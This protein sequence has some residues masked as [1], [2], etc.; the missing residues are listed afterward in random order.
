MLVALAVG[1]AIGFGMTSAAA[2]ASG[3]VPLAGSTS[4]NAD[5][6]ARTLSKLQMRFP[7]VMVGDNGQV[8][9]ANPL[10][11]IRHTH[12]FGVPMVSAPSAALAAEQFI[13]EYRAV[14]GAGQVTL[15]LESVDDVEFGKFTLF[16]YTQSIDGMPV[17]LSL[18]RVLVLNPNGHVHQPTVVLASAKLAEVSQQGFPA[19]AISSERALK[20]VQDTREFGHLPE[21]STPEL[22]VYFAEGD[23]QSFGGKWI[24]PVRVWRFTGSNPV[25][26]WAQKRTFFVDAASGKL[27]FARNEILH[28]PGDISGV[29]RANITPGVLPDSTTNPPQPVLFPDVRVSGVFNGGPAVNL[30]SDASG[31]FNFPSVPAGSAVLTANVAVGRWFTLTETGGAAIT[32]SASFTAPDATPGVADILLNAVP[33]EISTAQA[34]AFYHAHR[35]REFLRSR[36]PTF[37]AL[38]TTSGGGPVQINTSVSGTCNAFYNGNSINFYRAGGGCVNTAF[39]DVISH[40]FGH[41]VVNRR[42]LSQGAFGEGYGDSLGI[43]LFDIGTIGNGF[44]GPGTAIRRPA[45]ANQQFPCSSSAIHTCGQILGG[46]MY[47]YKELLKAS[48]GLAPGLAFGRQQFANWTLVTAGGQSLNSAHLQTAVELLTIDDVD[49]NI[50]NGTPNYAL[51]ANAFQQHGIAVP[52]VS[53]VTFTYNPALPGFFVPGQATP[54]VVTIDGNTATPILQSARLVYRVPPAGT[55]GGAGGPY[56]EVPMTVVTSNT[57]TASIPAQPCGSRVEFF[58]RVDTSNGTQAF[59]PASANA[60]TPVPFSAPVGGATLPIALDAFETDSGW[61]RATSGDTATTGLWSRM[62]PQLTTFAT[63]VI[64]QPGSDTTPT[65]GVNCWVTDGNAGTAAGTFDVDGGFTSLTSAPLPL[66]G[67]AAPVIRYNRWFF[68][69]GTDDTFTVDISADGSTNWIRVESVNAPGSTVTGSWVAR[70][71]RVNDFIVP[72]NQTRLRFRAADV[73]TGTIVEAAIDDFEI[74]RVDCPVITCA[75]DF[76]RTGGLTSQDLFDFLEAWFAGCIAP[77][78]SAPACQ[79]ASA[80]I[81]ASGNLEVQDIFDFVTVWFNGCP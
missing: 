79:N 51:L 2:V 13:N 16:N 42:G 31:A 72:T 35:S 33:T 44:S 5:L 25:P 53:L 59:S 60:V 68:G 78:T 80:D 30:L 74:R 3:S 22:V 28:G 62:T 47:E 49:G 54:I 69:S 19:A 43:W 8:D 27:V 58:V 1:A 57:L 15:E 40:E 7:G 71:F 24:T 21:W 45:T 12:I 52:A 70:E 55:S 6:A 18:A 81:N 64:A 41:H 23:E 4:F 73:G 39:S 29:V 75:A 46:V 26:K 65:P 38:D 50:S 61:A 77:N 76:N 20:S 14:F 56:V 36:A 17:D 11:P 48:L 9:R 67:V 37:T 66:G 10:A 32:A 63:G 34:N